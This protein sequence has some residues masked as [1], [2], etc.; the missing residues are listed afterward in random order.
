M[1]L[2]IGNG[3]Q[4]LILPTCTSNFVRI[5]SGVVL[6]V[7]TQTSIGQNDFEQNVVFLFGLFANYRFYKIPFAD[8][9][10]FF[11]RLNELWSKWLFMS[12]LHQEIN[13]TFIGNTLG[14]K[15]KCLF[16]LFRPSQKYWKIRIS[17]FFF[18]LNFAFLNKNVKIKRQNTQQLSLQGTVS[19]TRS[20]GIQSPTNARIKPM[21]PKNAHMNDTA[22]LLC[23]DLKKK[24]KKIDRPTDPPDFQAKRANKPFIFLGLTYKPGPNKKL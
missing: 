21:L 6:F 10:T 4:N 24:G 11:Y 2:L 23:Q 3:C 5:W 14:L 20:N 1:P 18:I 16:A 12:I 22:F 17:F 13:I 19:V 8:Y 7:Q 9:S 15:K